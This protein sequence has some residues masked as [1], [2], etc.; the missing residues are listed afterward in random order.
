MKKFLMP[1]ILSL[2]EILDWLATD[3]AIKAV[4]PSEMYNFEEYQREESTYNSGL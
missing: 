3:P 1:F 4:M 2:G